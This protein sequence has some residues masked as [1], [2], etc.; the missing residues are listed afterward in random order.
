M[1]DLFLKN[2]IIGNKVNQNIHQGIATTTGNIAEGLPVHYFLKRN[3]KKVKGGNNKLLQNAFIIL[4]GVP[5]I[6][7]K[8]RPALLNSC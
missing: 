3:I 1:N 2:K 4:T 8:L 5:K 7:K 6:N